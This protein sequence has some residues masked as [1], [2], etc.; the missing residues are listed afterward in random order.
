MIQTVVLQAQ[1]KQDYS[2]VQG[3]LQIKIDQNP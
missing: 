2:K 1:V 3:L